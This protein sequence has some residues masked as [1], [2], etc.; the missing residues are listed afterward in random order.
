[1]SLR[2]HLPACVLLVVAILIGS[3]HIMSQ[4]IVT[5]SLGG[6]V[7]DPS[8]A[9][10]PGATVTAVQNGTNSASRTT[11]GGAGQF[12]LPGLPIGTYTVT[13]ESSG[14][15]PVKVENVLVQTGKETPLGALTLK[16]GASESVVTVEG[17]AAILQPDSVQISQEFDTVKT[18][19]LPIGNGFDI[20]ALL[21]PG[22]APAG[23]NTFTSTNGAEFSS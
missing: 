18:A 22:V 7:Q 3:D 13:V 17:A 12:Q 11:T 20:V 23:G 8:S 10:I 21:V 4:G 16:I 1:M 9:V 19:N 14:F 2:N 6:T 15:V 5:G